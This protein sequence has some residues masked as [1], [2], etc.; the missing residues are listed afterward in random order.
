MTW[1]ESF[2][3]TSKIFFKNTIFSK[4]IQPILITH[5]FFQKLK[6]DN[7]WIDSWGLKIFCRFKRNKTSQSNIL[8][9]TF[10][11][12]RLQIEFFCY[13]FGMFNEIFKVSELTTSLRITK[14]MVRTTE[15]TERSHEWLHFYKEFFVLYQCSLLFIH[16]VIAQ[17][18]SLK[19]EL[20]SQ[21]GEF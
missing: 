12:N 17:N 4:Q 1:C 15:T 11:T 16:L 8:M 19:Y 13:V 10:I 21:V 18:H 9:I 6:V 7:C 2:I 5:P 20:C 14:L 3:A